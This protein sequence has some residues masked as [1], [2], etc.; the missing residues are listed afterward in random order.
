MEYH[1]V[2]IMGP[3]ILKLLTQYRCIRRVLLLSS[4]VRVT[5]F[6]PIHVWICGIRTTSTPILPHLLTTKACSAYLLTAIMLHSH[7]TLHTYV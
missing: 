7:L 1:V 6:L 2:K 5:V 3:K 4:D